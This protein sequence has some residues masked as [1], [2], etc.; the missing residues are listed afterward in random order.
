MHQRAFRWAGLLLA[1]LAGDIR[2]EVSG[3]AAFGKTA[4]GAMVDLFTLKNKNGVVAKLITLGAT[5]TELHVPD[6]NGKLADVVLG[7]ESV[8]EY[9]SPANQHFGCTTGRVANR[10]GNA[11]FTLDGKEYKLAANNGVHHLH[12]GVKR[13]LARVV[14]QAEPVKGDNAVRFR[15][16]SPDGEEGYPGMVQLTVTYTLTDKN[17][18][19]I[20]YLATTDK[21]TP[22]NLTNHSYF[23]LAG[24]GAKTVLEHELTV[25]ADRYTPTDEGL[26]PT[27]K[28]EPVAGTPLDFRKPAVVRPRVEQLLKTPAIGLDHNFILN[29]PDLQ[30]PAAKLREP[31]S[32]RVL[33]AYTDQPGIQVYSGN[34]LKGQTGKG[35]MTYPQRSAICLETQHFPDAVNRPN[36]PSIILKPGQ[37]YKQTCIYAFSTE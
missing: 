12:G 1:A 13:N 9:E 26:I 34:F 8:K 22:L 18:L 32:G 19:R 5:V 24:A 21:A 3:P 27:G 4:E 37:T 36:F 20:D 11:R 29:K 17:E 10:I 15:Y 6:K 33:T 35:G 16:T 14:W 25:N 7:F 31:G 28:L 30:T 23:N 2:A